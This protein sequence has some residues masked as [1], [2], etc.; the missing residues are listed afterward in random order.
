MKRLKSFQKELNSCSR[1]GLC[2]AV[3]PIYQITKNDCTSPRGKFILLNELLKTS[4][5]P[6]KKLK[7]YMRMCIDC[8]KC[9]KSCPSKI[10]I[11]KINKAFD[12]DFSFF[13]FQILFRLPFLIKVLCIYLKYFFFKKSFDKIPK[14]KTIIYQK[15]FNENLPE[16]IENCIVI[17]EDVIPFKF[18]VENTQLYDELSKLYAKKIIDYNPDYII[19]KTPFLRLE[20]ENGLKSL[21]IKD[22][23]K[24]LFVR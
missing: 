11:I 14:N 1:C 17:E 5:N 16:Y 10:D 13:N 22:N 12:K 15:D 9:Y 7:Q 3:C 6:S 8:G 19:T 21:K 20:L 23:T 4:K 2:Q 18:A 24:I